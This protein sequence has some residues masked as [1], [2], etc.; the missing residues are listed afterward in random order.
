MEDYDMSTWSRKTLKFYQNPVTLVSTN[1]ILDDKH[2]KDKK[3]VFSTPTKS[4][5][6]GAEMN[7]FNILPYSMNA[8][9]V[10]HCK[11]Q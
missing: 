7:A 3:K 2:P 1:L 8:I 5:Y 11:T 10:Q 6:V 9:R 4:N